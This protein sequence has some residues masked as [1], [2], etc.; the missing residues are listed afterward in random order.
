MTQDRNRKKRNAFPDAND[1]GK[2]LEGWRHT[3]YTVIF[4][5]DTKIGKLFD[6]I[7]IIA[8][9]LSL[10]VI[11]ADSVEDLS[12]RYGHVF[13]ILEWTFT[14]LFTLEYLLRL[15][16]VKHRWRYALSFYGIV[17]LLAVAP[18]YAALL[19]PNMAFL[20]G[21]R[22][23]RLLRVFRVFKLAAFV[24]E[25]VMLGR[26]LRASARKILVF[27]SV[28]LSIVLVMG[29]IMYVVEG[30]TRGFISIPAGVYWAI[31]TLSTVG[32][33]DIT[34][35]TGLGRFLASVMMLLGW[36]VLAVPTGI[37]TLE[38]GLA[39]KAMR[40]DV[41]TRTCHECLKEGLDADAN[42][43]KKCGAKLSEYQ[44]D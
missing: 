17:D 1:L 23:L 4:E 43:C 9:L 10:A 35:Q 14:G 32:F 38:L 33:G 28:V 25:Y 11:M 41:T 40:K 19:F 34:P 7:L 16:C 12:S 18:T 39:Q 5:A 22:A 27:L 44:N 42:F 6:L 3:L 30:P 21:V 29:T 20:I 8:I 13:R 24:D 15:I 37:V 26:A 31:T 36:G 2:P